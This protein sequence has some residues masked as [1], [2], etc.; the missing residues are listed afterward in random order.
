MRANKPNYPV[1]YRGIDI[2]M[3]A[4]VRNTDVTLTAKQCQE[5]ERAVLRDWGK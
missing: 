2:R 3:H 1:E 4:K 5:R